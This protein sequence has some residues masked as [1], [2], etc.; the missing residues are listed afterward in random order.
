MK[1]L[2][3]LHYNFKIIKNYN[4]LIPDNNKINFGQEHALIILLLK[5]GNETIEN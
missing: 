1:T 5:P 2:K 4:K 3:I